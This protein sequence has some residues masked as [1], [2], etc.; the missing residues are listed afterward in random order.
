M[1]KYQEAAGDYTNAIQIDDRKS[2]Y[3]NSRGNAFFHL[4]NY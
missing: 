2:E 4:G 1:G 3:Y